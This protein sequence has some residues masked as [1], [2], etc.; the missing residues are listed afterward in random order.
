MRFEETITP[1][2]SEVL[3]RLHVGGTDDSNTIDVAQRLTALSERGLFESVASLYAFSAPMGWYVHEV[4]FGFQDGPIDDTTKA[5]VREIAKWLHSEWKAGRTVLARCQAGINRSCLTMALVL[6][7]EGYSATAAID[8]IRDK[9]FRH[10]LSN[11]HFVRF[12]FEEEE[13]LR[14][15]T[16]AA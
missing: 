1:L 12:I 14:Q 16:L 6:L 13:R 7:E 10:A 8:L 9:R 2:T 3:P 4:R 15:S 5:K 11:Q